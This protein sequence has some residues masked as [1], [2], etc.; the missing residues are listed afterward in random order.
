[1]ISEAEF[2]QMQARVA[3]KKTQPVAS[4]AREYD[5][6]QNIM[7]HCRAKGWYFVHSRMDRATTT[8]LGVP[9]LIIAMPDGVTVWVECKAK[10]GKVSIE[11]MAVGVMLEHLGHR[12][13]LVHSLE[14][15]LNAVKPQP[16]TK[17]QNENEVSCG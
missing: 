6:H 3:P 5:L 4:V 15:F 16:T 1:M 12:Y 13:A 9:D 7:L 11:Q 2:Q 14:E 17:E 10:G 8:Q